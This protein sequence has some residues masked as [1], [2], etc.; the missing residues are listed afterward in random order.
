MQELAQAIKYLHMMGLVYGDLKEVRFYHN[1]LPQ[2]HF[3]HQSALGQHI[4]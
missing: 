3:S 4:D 1:A 2:E